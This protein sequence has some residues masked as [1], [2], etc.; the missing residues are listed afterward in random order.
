MTEVRLITLDPA[1]FHA[2]LVQKEMYPQVNKRVHVYAPL[3]TDLMAHLNRILGFNTRKSGPTAWD[4]EVH[5]SGDF[6]QRMIAEKPGNVVILSGRNH[7][8]I[9]YILGAVQNGINVLADKPWILRTEDLG[10]LQT[11]LDTADE[12]GLI[13]YDIMTERFEI[14]TI[15]QRELVQDANVAGTVES[16]S[17]D[18]PAVYMESVHYLMKKVA[19]VSLLRPEW[20]F[21]I[22]KQGEGLTDVGTH[23]V[24]LVP[25]LLFPEQPM[26]YRKDIQIQAGKRWPTVISRDDYT[27]VSG[28][29]DF[30]DYLQ[31][32]LKDDKLEYFCNNSVSYTV[33]G[34]HVHLDVRW[35]FEAEPGAG[36]KHLAIIRGNRATVEI[37]QGKEQN[38]RPELYVVPGPDQMDSVA[39]AL[40]TKIEQ[41]QGKYVGVGLEK[42]G[43]EF[44]IL[45]PDTY[46]I[47]HE[48]H[49][50]EVTNQF[51]KYLENPKGLPTWEKPN[52]LAKYYVTTQGVAASL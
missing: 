16:G 26:D 5:A 27:H 17:A 50:A 1:H 32:W 46:R 38:Y 19:G 13:A 29:V 7:A 3:G 14:T 9:D 15:L 12:K 24:D 21:D 31:P 45:I 40:K 20:Y 11:A 47:G 35:D 8:K 52:M 4:L 36:D 34:V 37:R 23:L 51:L 25:W 10:K 28:A 42:S 33:R 18:Q 39:A 22:T 48:A 44:H 41:L 30:P 49:F 6:V 43:A 2:A